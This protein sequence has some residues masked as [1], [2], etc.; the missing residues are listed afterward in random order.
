[1]RLCQTG[2]DG[3]IEEDGSQDEGQVFDV[4]IR[5]EKQARRNQPHLSGNDQSSLIQPEI[6]EE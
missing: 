2:A 1:M 4:P 3:K 5:I 6:N